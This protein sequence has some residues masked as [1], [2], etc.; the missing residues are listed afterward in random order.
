MR[1]LALLFSVS[2]AFAPALA[3]ASTAGVTHGGAS[4]AEAMTLSQI[5]WKNFVGQNKGKVLNQTGLT[6]AGQ[7]RQ[8][9]AYLTIDPRDA[10]NW[11]AGLATD[12]A[13]LPAG[14]SPDRIR[15]RGRVAAS[16]AGPISVRLESAPSHWLGFV[17]T[18]PANEEWL[19]FDWPLSEAISQGRFSLA[20]SKLRL[21]VTYR[22]TSGP[23][24]SAPGENTL[25]LAEATVVINP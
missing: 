14:I 20:A 15:L 25:Y 4:F 13:A 19:D 8:R 2:L 5:G 9:A 21:V 24:W 1:P 18:A 16:K 17:F 12:I 22:D 7:P 23:V 6:L 3:P 10:E 11:Y